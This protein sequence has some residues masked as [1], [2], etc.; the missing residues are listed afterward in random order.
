MEY[1]LHSRLGDSGKR[2]ETT[3]WGLGQTPYENKFGAFQT[4]HD[5]SGG[6][7]I[8]QFHVKLICTEADSENVSEVYVAVRHK[9]SCIDVKLVCFHSTAMR[10]QSRRLSLL[11]SYFN[12]S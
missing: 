12:H 10:N 6:G 8:K 3:Q 5:T 9:N 11:A 4:L 2:R 1:E 7:I